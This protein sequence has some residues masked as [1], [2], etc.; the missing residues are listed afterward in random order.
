MHQTTKPF[1]S[2]RC[3]T[4]DRRR[5]SLLLPALLLAEHG[6]CAGDDGQC[7]GPAV[8]NRCIAIDLLCALGWASV[9]SDDPL[10]IMGLAL[11]LNMILC[12]S[13]LLWTYFCLPSSSY[14]RL[15]Y[16]IIDRFRLKM[17]R[18]THVFSMR[19]WRL[20]SAR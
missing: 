18:I 10:A 2:T 11:G 17:R 1:A 15:A 8:D 19:S 12:S 4:G 5:T 7:I 13:V 9:F 20:G 3:V 16:D 6:L 14:R